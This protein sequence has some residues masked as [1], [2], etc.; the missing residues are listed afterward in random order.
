MYIFFYFSI[1]NIFMYITV[2]MY[3]TNSISRSVTID[4][5]ENFHK[6]ISRKPPER[7]YATRVFQESTV[8]II[9]SIFTTRSKYKKFFIVFLSLLCIAGFIYHCVSFMN[10]VLAY[11]EIIDIYEDSSK[12]YDIPAYTYCYN[13]P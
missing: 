11:P 10:H 12:K 1:T 3:H 9:S 5:D 6:S 2:K 13:S 8:G 7:S 4:L